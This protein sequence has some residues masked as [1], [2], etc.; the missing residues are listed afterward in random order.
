[1]RVLVTGGAGYVGSHVLL[2]LHAAGHETTTVDGL[3]TGHRFLAE[4][5]GTD[6][7]VGSI[8]N[9]GWI[10]ALVRA[11]RIEAVVHLAAKALVSE[12]M[13]D[14]AGYL[15]AN[16]GGSAALFGAAYRGGVR[17]FVVSSTG[18]VY[19]ESRQVPMDE[20]HPIAPVNPY[21]ASKRLMEALLEALEPHGVRWCALRYFNAAGADP[22]GRGGEPHAH[23][24]HLFPN[25]FAAA[26]D[27]RPAPVHGTDFPTLDGTAIR[28]Y[29]HVSD[30]ADAHVAALERLG[31]TSL[32]PLN[33]GT[34]TG[35]SVRE[36]I[37][38]VRRVTGLP[39]EERA[40][41][42]RPGDPARLVADP[43]KAASLLGFRP[44]RSTPDTL[45]STAWEWF[46][47]ARDTGPR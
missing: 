2:A 26:P 46:R 39:L 37:A 24:T 29:V 32:G 3:S 16:V 33:L 4:A 14:P 31:T 36:V 25:L 17:T 9:S 35:L 6:L 10:E 41:P 42:R 40:L 18:A 44:T 5:A 21:G 45:V 23:E 43:G 11:R 1:M 28:D 47:R 12:S 30:L 15:A 13:S 20:T 8:E 27:G 22:Q 19:G 7:Q 34:G 38:A